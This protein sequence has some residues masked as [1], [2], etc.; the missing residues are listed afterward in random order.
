MRGVLNKRELKK[1]DRENLWAYALKSVGQRAQTSS[2]V[3]VKLRRRAAEPD[4]VEATLAKLKEYGFL[5]DRRFAETYAE[6]R[7]SNQGF[8]SGRALRDLQARRVAPAVAEQSVQKV[9]A[10]Q[11]EV[12]LIEAYIRRK[13][14]TASR[15]TLFA[16]DK[17]MASAFRRLRV[18]GFSTGNVV[19]VLKRFASKPELLD[20]VEDSEE[21]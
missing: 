1:L 8:G 11:D 3:R 18:A 21:G 10:E 17:D 7:L 6:S 14:R 4:D 13:Y 2:E 19:K 12:A 20:G 15:E 9:Y 5:D 16:E